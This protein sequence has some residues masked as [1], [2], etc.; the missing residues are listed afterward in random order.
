YHMAMAYMGIEDEEQA[1]GW[2]EKAA[3]ENNPMLVFLNV[4]QSWDALRD[5]PE[6]ADILKQ[7]NLED[8]SN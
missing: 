7:V 8:Y 2:L 1:I 4:D 5:R 3:A 6:F